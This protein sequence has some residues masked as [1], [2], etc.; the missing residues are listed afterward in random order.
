MTI[1][2][3]GL[4]IPSKTVL[5]Q[6][7]S[8]KVEV[9]LFKHLSSKGKNSEYW[10]KPEHF[11]VDSS[12]DNI[13]DSYSLNRNSSLQNIE[14]LSTSRESEPSYDIKPALARYDMENH[15][16]SPLRNGLNEI[17]SR[18]YKLANSA[19]HIRQSQH[20]K[21]LAHFAWTQPR[22]S[23]NRSLPI[24]FTKSPYN[25][26]LPEGE[27][28][29]HVS[30]FLHMNVDLAQTECVPVKN[31]PAETVYKPNSTAA[32]TMT[33]TGHTSEC[34]EYTYQ[35]KQHRK[36][37]SRELHYLDNPVFGMLVYITPI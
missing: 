4:S 5:A 19:A 29:L 7:S 24:L 11:K 22:L 1:F 27:I 14:D 30:R 17:S 34:I 20:F 32:S 16:F 10:I 6:A 9:V 35:F 36:M 15:T 28:K 23:E 3:L 33:Y 18:H 37:R 13:L 26:N 25:E 8:Y 21:L 2:A 31:K 12:P